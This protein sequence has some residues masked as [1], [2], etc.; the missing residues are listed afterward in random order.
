[1]TIL[2]IG[3]TGITLARSRNNL[4]GVA[5]HPSRQRLMPQSR[6]LSGQITPTRHEEQPI[7]LNDKRCRYHQE[8][9]GT[10]LAE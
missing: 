9:W 3:C 7:L 6:N 5:V 10:L 1:M 4:V 2:R 8:M